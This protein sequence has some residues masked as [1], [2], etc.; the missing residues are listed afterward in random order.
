[1]SATSYTVAQTLAAIDDLIIQATQDRSHYY[2]AK[3]LRVARQTIEV[4]ARY[5][6]HRPTCRSTKIKNIYAKT[7]T[8]GF[9]D[10]LKA[11]P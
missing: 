10:D 8:C 1:M 7:C 9:D 11:A 3:V 4:L 2:A 6:D 5:A